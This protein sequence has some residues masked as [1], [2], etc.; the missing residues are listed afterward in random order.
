MH[1]LSHFSVFSNFL[2]LIRRNSL[3]YK[4]YIYLVTFN[5]ANSYSITL[6]GSCE[7]LATNK[8]DI[9]IYLHFFTHD[10]IVRGD[11]YHCDCLTGYGFVD[12]ESPMAAEGAVKALVAKGIQAQMAKV[13]IWLLRRLDSVR[14]C[15]CKYRVIPK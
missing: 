5:H 6:F 9:N 15:A 3:F 8:M 10:K 1:A 7:I 12:F 2:D 14:G 4:E 13:G 11:L